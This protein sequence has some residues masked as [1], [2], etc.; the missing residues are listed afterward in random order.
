MFFCKKCIYIYISIY[1]IHYKKEKNRCCCFFLF[2][3]G[4]FT[5]MPFLGG[6][7]RKLRSPQN[8]QLP[9][10]EKIGHLP[11]LSRLAFKSHK[12][13]NRFAMKDLAGYKARS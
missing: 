2:S 12:M 1:C 4:T 5:M 8:C 10:I 9:Y 7:G 6:G 13:A 3:D 11:G